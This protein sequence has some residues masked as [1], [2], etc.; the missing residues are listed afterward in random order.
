M[1]GT[2]ERIEELAR[3]NPAAFHM[4]C[5]RAGSHHEDDIARGKAP[6]RQHGAAN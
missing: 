4:A 1:Q 3:D 2:V 6:A 5:A